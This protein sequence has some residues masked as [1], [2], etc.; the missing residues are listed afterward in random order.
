[1]SEWRVFGTEPKDGSD[2]LCYWQPFYGPAQIVVAR[3]N[4]EL[5]FVGLYAVDP[6]SLD[7]RGSISRIE[8]GFPEL[9]VLATHWMPLPPPPQMKGK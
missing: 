6:K 8:G 2:F 5:P 4:Q 1:M 3:W 7:G 9:K